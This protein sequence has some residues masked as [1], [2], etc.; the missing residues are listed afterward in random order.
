MLLANF[1]TIKIIFETERRKKVSET[2][3]LQINQQVYWL[4][5]LKRGQNDQVDFPNKFVA[6][7]QYELF[8]GAS[9]AH[10]ASNS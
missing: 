7:S 1:I 3:S 4:R 9:E 10:S 5:F 8:R 6:S 2:H